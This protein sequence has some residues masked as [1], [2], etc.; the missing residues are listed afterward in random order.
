MVPNAVGN[1]SFLFDMYLLKLVPGHPSVETDIL[2]LSKLKEW[3][4]DPE[5]WMQ[6][7]E[8]SHAVEPPVFQSPATDE[9]HAS[10]M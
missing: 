9:F 8:E 2:A 6:H 10:V 4:N 3:L 1:Q 7:Q 5:N